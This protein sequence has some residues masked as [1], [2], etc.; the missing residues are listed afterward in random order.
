MVEIG[1]TD[2]IVHNKS[3]IK[4]LAYI[5][6]SWNNFSSLKKLY[7][8]SSQKARKSTLKTKLQQVN[9]WCSEV[10][11][12]LK[13]CA[14]LKTFPSMNVSLLSQA[15][16]HKLEVIKDLLFKVGQLNF[17]ISDGIF[18]TDLR[19]HMKQQEVKKVN[20]M[21]CKSDKLLKCFCYNDSN[22]TWKTH[23]TTSL[24]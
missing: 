7:I 21:S 14:E 24:I 18:L 17:K 9:Y 19:H 8:S 16:I 11:D 3:L 12:L 2:G 1:F 23:S 10:V 20:I 22:L 5:S 4:I 13:K 15:Y 6:Y